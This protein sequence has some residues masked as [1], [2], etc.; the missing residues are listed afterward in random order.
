M[1][2]GR[3]STELKYWGEMGG[4]GICKFGEREGME[5]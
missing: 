1:S 3:E 4:L 5:D 2:Q